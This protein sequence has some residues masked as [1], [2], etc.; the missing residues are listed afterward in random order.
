MLHYLFQE[1]M[2]LFSVTLELIMIMTVSFFQNIMSSLQNMLENVDS[3]GIQQCYQS[4][5]F[6]ILHHNLACFTKA[7]REL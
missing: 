3:S 6:M 5:K 2:W 7:M 1:S 4:P